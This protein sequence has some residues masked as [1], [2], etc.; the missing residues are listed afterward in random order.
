MNPDQIIEIA[1]R[2]DLGEGDHTTLAT[3]PTGQPGKARLLIK[4]NGIL[5]GV[6][7]AEAVFRKVD[8]L[9]QMEVFIRDGEPVYAGDIVFIVS[10]SMASILKAER[11]VLNFMQR[12][13]G[14]AT[15]TR[16]VTS[17][18]EG[19]VCKVLDTRKTTP[20]LRELEK[21]AVVTGGGENHRA[22]LYDMI[23]IKD[24]HVDAA[25]G[26]ARAL[27]AVAGY[28]KSIGKRMRVEIEVRSM[29]ELEEVLLHGGTDRIMLDNFPPDLLREAVI[30]IG[31]RFETEASGGITPAN[32]RAYAVTGVDYIS[33]GSL[34]H[35]VRSL[36]MSLKVT[37]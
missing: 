23:L 7:L 29:E 36:D 24:N 18:L 30:R 37:R 4:E 14:I 27:D 3:V 19:L 9:L 12:M 2:E 16:Q 26:P 33:M 13:S 17:L 35:H 21:Y 10:G 28:L 8:P 22:G 11:L 6:R 20:G 1:L 25:G 32:I 34:T 31:G 15:Q 5:C